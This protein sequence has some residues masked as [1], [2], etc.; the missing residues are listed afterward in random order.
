MIVSL[1]KL[2][3]Q[4]T[5]DLSDDVLKDKLNALEQ[6]VRN[7]TNNHF[8]VRARRAE[9]M[10]ADGKLY[11]LRPLFAVGDTVEISESLYNNGVY[12]VQAVED[13]ITTLS[14]KL[15]DEPHALVTLVRY[16]ADIQQ[17]VIDLVKWDL[18]NRDKVGIASET[19]SRHS[20]TY[21]SMDGDNSA[22]GYPKA[23]TGFLKGYK[24]ARF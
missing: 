10:I 24:K 3:S 5:T 19:I 4:I 16:P 13:K 12:T 21:F 2:R 23:L 8:Q 11:M 9:C 22:L 6:M 14:E 18:N 7:A 17:G 20:V 1:K 15:I